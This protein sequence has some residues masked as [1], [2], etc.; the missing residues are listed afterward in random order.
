M[1]KASE[2]FPAPRKLDN[3]TSRTPPKIREAPVP[4]TDAKKE[5][6]K[7]FAKE[8]STSL[9]KLGERLLD[10]EKRMDYQGLVEILNERN[11]LGTTPQFISTILPFCLAS[12]AWIA[13]STKDYLGM[14][15]TL[16]SGKPPKPKLSN[17]ASF[18]VKQFEP[19]FE[20]DGGWRRLMLSKTNSH[21][22][23]VTPSCAMGQRSA[24]LFYSKWAFDCLKCYE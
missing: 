14:K 15:T 8:L 18:D 23:S 12:D 13:S 19:E 17:L 9:F 16:C 10:K 7:R 6:R 22:R 4:K 21:V 1:K 5:R 3:T 11:E 2:I 24:G 20:K